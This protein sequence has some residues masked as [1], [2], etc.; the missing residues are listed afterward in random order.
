M[1][2][3]NINT[4]KI[5]GGGAEPSNN[6][7]FDLTQKEHFYN[8]DFLR[9]IGACIIFLFHYLWYRLCTIDNTF[10]NLIFV[11]TGYLFVSYFFIIAGF[12]LVYTFNN[13]LS[14]M[15]F[16]KKKICRFWPL[17][18]FGI[19]LYGIADIL[20]FIKHFDLYRNILSLLFLE[21]AGVTL[22]WGNIGHDWFVSVL[23]FVSIFYFY[24]FKYFKKTSYNFFISILVIL[25][26]T[27]LVHV[28]K[29]SIGGHIKTVN[30][31]FNIG[32]IIGLT[33]LGLGYLLHEFYQYLKSQPFVKSLKSTV[34]Y[35][36]IEA[37]LLCFVI[38]ETGFHKIH[39]DNKIILIVAFVGLFLTF[40]LKRGIISNLLNNKFSA[41]LGQYTFSLYMTHGALWVYLKQLILLHKSL[42]VA[43]PY[44]CLL[45]CFITCFIFAILTYHFVEVPAGKFLK[46][47]FFPQ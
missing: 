5:G 19:L 41:I 31:F 43:H 14:V 35:T 33:G 18:A 39:F 1:K 27:F 46:K 17:I 32:I 21:N 22:K 7:A 16:I 40:L 37:Y 12:F 9:F 29:G 20:G 15:D 6:N 3:T 34:I 42:C 8:V 47:K 2:S 11:G 44:L 30:N 36:F 28:T 23:F 45:G 10:K 13:N 26:Y 4:L 25:G 24:I 38:Y